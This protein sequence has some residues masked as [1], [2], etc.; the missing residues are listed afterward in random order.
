MQGDAAADVRWPALDEVVGGLGAEV[1]RAVH[2]APGESPAVSDVLLYDPTDPQSVRA[3]AIVLA[4]GVSGTAG[5]AFAVIDAAA[6][7]GAAAVVLRGDAEPLERILELARTA[8]IALIEVSSEVSWGHL[9]SLLRTALLSAGTVG[10]AEV[11]GVPVGDLFALADA[12]AAAVGGAV[13]IEDPQW[14]VLAYSNLG[15]PIDEPRRDTILGRIPPLAWL[16]RIEETGVGRALRFGDEVVHLE[17]DGLAPRLAAPVRVGGEL[18]GSIWVAEGEAAL[19]A[20]AEAELLRAAQQATVHLISHRASEDIR[21]RMRGSF[22]REVL[23][24]RLGPRAER[25]LRSAKGPFTV[26]AFESAS[27][28]PDADLMPAERV[29]SIMSL[30]CEDAHPEA[31]CAFIDHRFW[32]VVPLSGGRERERSIALARKVTG[33]VSRVSPIRLV[34]GIGGSVP[35]VADIP[36]SRRAAERALA[37]LG[38][39]A[40][41][42]RVVHIADVRARA[43]LLDLL[44]LVAE[45]ADL[46]EGALARLLAEDADRADEHRATLRAYLDCSGN[47]S[48]AAARLGI[49]PNTLRYRISRLVEHSGLDLNDPDERLV[50]ELQLRMPG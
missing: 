42:E 2:A 33:A 9:Y 5:D 32:A 1:L 44:E 36:R 50:T 29:L 39:R 49:H 38:D 30:Y 12:T 23:E 48:R 16:R 37:V 28:E 22:V 40:A 11:A 13:T 19:G 47:I 45:R 34:A 3:D 27:G 7:S 8:G 21:R 24:G 20:D 46:R 6:R 10:R 4:V 18:L 25:D 26:L 35:T 41:N 31:M 14:R 17:A 15:H 43:V